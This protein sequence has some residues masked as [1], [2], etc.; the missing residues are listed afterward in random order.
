MA[1]EITYASLTDLR[2]AELLHKTIQ[3]LLHDP[4]DLRKT[5]VFQP[6]MNNAGSS[7]MKTGQVQPIYSMSAPGEATGVANTALTDASFLLTIAKY[8]LQQELTDLAQITAPKGGLDMQK[9]ASMA[10][11]SVTYNLSAMLTAA[12]ASV[13]ANVTDTGV[14]LT[15]DHISTAQYTL[16]QADVP[17]PYYCVLAKVQFTD[18]QDSLEGIG[19]PLQWVAATAEMLNIKGPGYKGNWKG[20]EFYTHASVPTVN[21]GADYA[22]CMYGMGAFAYTEADTGSIEKFL[23]T[24]QK[25]PGLKALVEFKRPDDANGGTGSTRMITHTYPAVSISENARAVKIVTDA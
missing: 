4:T 6:F 9:L 11:M 24:Y 22:G 7:A 16:E 14:N 25:L 1:N 21:A 13:T 12:F 18:F 17:G 8:N 3:F 20:I 2:V 5:M 15:T 10:G 23:S 19:G